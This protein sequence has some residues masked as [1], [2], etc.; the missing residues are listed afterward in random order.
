[1]TVRPDPD[2]TAID[3]AFAAAVQQARAEYSTRLRILA[4]NWADGLKALLTLSGFTALVAAPLAANTLSSTTRVIVGGLFSIVF[5]TGTFGLMLVLASASG[6]TKRYMVP[7]SYTELTMLERSI[8]DRAIRNLR[9]GRA[10]TITALM[11]ISIIILVAW[12]DPWKGRV[13]LRVTVENGYTTC[14]TLVGGPDGTI[15][16]QPPDHAKDTLQLKMVKQIVLVA[17]CSKD[18]P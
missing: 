11:L 7:L 9:I 3:T 17:D 4:K 13:Q 10:L 5:L 15:T 14:G 2:Q 18:S 8:S 6:T 1:M 16:I 12:V